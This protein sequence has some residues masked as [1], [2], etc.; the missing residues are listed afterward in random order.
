M[1][2]FDIGKLKLEYGIALAPMAGFSDYAMRRVCHALGAEYSVTEMVSAKAVVYGDKK[3]ARLAKIRADEGPVGLQIF[4]SE[5]SVMAE[6]AAIL[7]KPIEDGVAPVLIDIN[8]GCPVPKIFGNGEGSALMKN[9]SLIYDIVKATKGA[10]SLPVSVKI[11]LGID[12]AHINAVECALA[13]EE[14][15]AKMLTVHGRT[16]VEMYSGSADMDEVAR[17]REKI[18]IPLFANGDITSAADA[19]RVLR[20]TGAE[21]VMIGRGAVGNPYIFSEIRAA[22]SGAEYREPS[23]SERA[24]LALF[25]LGLAISEKGEEAA[26]LE[27][28]KQIALYFKNFR[29]AAELR[30]RINT[31]TTYDE[32]ASAF[33]QMASEAQG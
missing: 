3:T 24:D 11:R 12:R 28:R 13:A 16:R 25:Q 22:L 1:M 5:P 29:G 9:P 23:L 6:A 19:V 4:G 14:A 21:G 15:G 8:M 26:V 30:A 7:E 27:A 10:T 17:V 20:H 33:A 31:A 2:S 18:K 32:V